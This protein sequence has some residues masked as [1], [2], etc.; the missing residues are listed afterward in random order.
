M[1]QY[2]FKTLWMLCAVLAALCSGCAMGPG[3][4]MVSEH[5][6]KKAGVER[7]TLETGRNLYAAKCSGCH[8][9]YHPARFSAKTWAV[10]V[11]E[12]GEQFHVK[13]T[14]Q[15]LIYG[16]LATF[17]RDETPTLQS[18]GSGGVSAPLQAEP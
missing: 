15:A 10:A 11:E 6:A 17:S 18:S 7:V 16:Y 12:M 2:G 1:K 4:P 8:E 14:D 3:L 5:D 9:L 13:K